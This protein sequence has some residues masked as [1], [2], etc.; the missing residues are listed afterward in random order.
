MKVQDVQR[1]RLLGTASVPRAVYVSCLL[2]LISSHMIAYAQPNTAELALASKLLREASHAA[3]AIKDD[4]SLNGCCMAQHWKLQVYNQIAAT[5]A[6]LRDKEGV[7]ET[8]ELA[9]KTAKGHAAAAL[10]LATI[11]TSQAQ[12]GDS[13]GGLNTLEQSLKAAHAIED[14]RVKN[15]VLRPIVR[16]FARAGDTQRALKV[17]D[18]INGDLLKVSAQADVAVAQVTM[19]HREAGAAIFEQAV[20]GASGI[21]DLRDR[22]WAY[23]NIALAMSKSSDSSGAKEMMKES[24]ATAAKMLDDA[25]KTI[26]LTA[27]GAG[28]SEL[29]DREEARHVLAQAINAANRIGKE[30]ERADNLWRIAWHLIRV[31][32]T[33]LL[34]SALLEAVDSAHKIQDGFF[35]ANALREIGE[36]YTKVGN[37]KAAGTLFEEAHRVSGR[38]PS[39]DAYTLLYLAKAE[40]D[41]G[42]AETASRT[43]HALGTLADAE[44]PRDYAYFYIALA[45]AR[46]GEFKGALRSLHAIRANAKLK[47][48]GS[49]EIARELTKRGNHEDALLWAE[50]L[51]TAQ[52]RTHAFLGVAQGLL[53]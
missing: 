45:Q 20:Q 24:V 10:P 3:D 34:T 53:E 51:P 9:V 32:D 14:D 16:G 49:Q 21:K 30:S 25:G 8:A 5:Q 22:A 18:S 43:A 4:E 39:R 23:H 50:S 46:S 41:A 19:G 36:V 27:L 52:T 44:V 15:S 42:D 17:A 48:E 2:F 28:Y 6:Q 11:G 33:P 40:A 7:T 31:G 37:T 13:R 35:K 38:T 12:A 47:A 1:L 26:F 29:G